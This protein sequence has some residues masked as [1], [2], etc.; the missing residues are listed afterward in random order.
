MEKVQELVK[1][2]ERLIKSF[3]LLTRNKE[4]AEDIYQDVCVKVL[5]LLQEGKYED[6]G[7]NLYWWLY[8]VG[9]NVWT[10]KMREKTRRPIF[11]FYSFDTYDDDIRAL[12][13]VLP[14]LQEGILLDS[15]IEDTIVTEEMYKLMYEGIDRL[16]DEF[17]YV[18]QAISLGDSGFKEIAEETGIS[19][20]TLLGRNRYAKR[21]IKKYMLEHI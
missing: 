3:K 18:I 8:T 5:P 20:N 15:N 12:Q 4:D 1:Q 6:R 9:K 21:R 14:D 16:P 17:K 7:H 13:D 2:R 11:E 19:I 10:D